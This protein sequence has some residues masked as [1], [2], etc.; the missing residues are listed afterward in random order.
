MKDVNTESF[1]DKLRIPRRP[2]LNI[3]NTFT[4][5]NLYAAIYSEREFPSFP[6]KIIKLVD[7]YIFAPQGFGPRG[8]KPEEAYIEVPA[9]NMISIYIGYIPDKFKFLGFLPAKHWWV[10]SQSYGG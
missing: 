8:P 3:L 4:T 1:V 10:T 2:V 7:T 9:C 6:L 5:Q